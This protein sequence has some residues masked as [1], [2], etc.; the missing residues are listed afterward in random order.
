MMGNLTFG[1]HSSTIGGP[2]STQS[3]RHPK[4]RCAVAATKQQTCAQPTTTRACLCPLHE[5]QVTA[6]QRR[7]KIYPTHLHRRCPIMPHSFIHDA[8]L[9]PRALLRDSRCGAERGCRCSVDEGPA[10][11]PSEQRRGMKFQ[12]STDNSL[13]LTVL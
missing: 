4:Y 2:S 9:Q 13:G 3:K 6:A 1:I 7:G 12:I 5:R 10:L 11:E 8:K